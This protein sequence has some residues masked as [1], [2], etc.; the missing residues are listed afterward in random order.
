M[1]R[2]IEKKTSLVESVFPGVFIRCSLS[3]HINFYLLNSQS[4]ASRFSCCKLIR[5]TCRLLLREAG[6][7]NHFVKYRKIPSETEASLMTLHLHDSRERERAVMLVKKVTYFGEFAYL[8]SSR[9]RK[10]II[11]TLFSSSRGKFTLL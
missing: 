5:H 1:S 3:T 4:K 10:I 2:K 11:L 7:L 6:N 9:I 8:N